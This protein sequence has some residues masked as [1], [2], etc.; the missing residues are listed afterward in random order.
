MFQLPFEY[1]IDQLNT[2]DNMTKYWCG[3]VSREHIQWGVS[4]GFCQVCHGKKHPL[5][6]MSVGDFIVFYSPVMMFNG[7]DKCQRFTALGRVVGETSYQFE[8]SPSFIPYRRDIDYFDVL[9]SSIY[10]L[11]NSLDFTKGNNNWGFKFRFGHF[12][13]SKKDFLLIKNKMLKN[14]SE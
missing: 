7:K 10:P 5:N 3:V 8:M 13:L 9:E 14:Q 4:G 2:R 1:G 11:L 12:E 6:R